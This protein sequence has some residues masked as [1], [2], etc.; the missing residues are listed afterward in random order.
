MSMAISGNNAM[1]QAPQ[2]W[3]GAS[4]KM[5]P[6]QKMTNLF[7]KIDAMGS[8][9]ITKDQLTQSLQSNKA[10]SSFQT[11]GI[12]KLWAQLDPSGTG[13][14]S[15][16][17]FTSKMVDIQTQLRAQHHHHHKG[18][19]TDAQ[20]AAQT[21]AQSAAALTKLGGDPKTTSMISSNVNLTA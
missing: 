8:G 16:Q 5:S 14:V 7:D 20:L 19:A 6:T 21:A 1:M 9:S 2:A 18:S 3:S 12:D 17:D 4:M 15:K 13:Q 11:I 10:P